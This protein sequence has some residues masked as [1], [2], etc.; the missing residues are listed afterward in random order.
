M[1]KA[2]TPE[3]LELMRKSGKIT[4]AALKKVL[5]AV[6]PGVNL[7]ELE[8]I[9][10]GEIKRLGGELSFPT[11]G[12]YKWA[13]CL[14]VNEELVHGI[15]RDIV[16]KKGD[17]LGIDI[18]AI[19]QG[20]HTDAAWS[21][22]VGGSGTGERAKFLQAGEEALWRAVKQAV[23]GKR[24]GDISNAIQ[25]TIEEAGFDVSRQLVGHGVG[26]EIHEKP[27]VP[28]FGRA[29]TGLE[30][31]VGMT[32]AIEAIYAQGNAY[33]SLADD[34]WTYVTKDG[35]LGGLFEMSVIVGKDKA[36]VLTDWRKI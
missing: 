4:A 8:E 6:V 20:Y 29:G 3:E 13:T 22:V 12:K 23:E 36:E 24:I 5:E 1:V 30:L 10:V 32:I 15:P 28:G 16:L 35:S 2:R 21:V 27:E 11:V 14:T 26:K 31:K 18:G 25:T 33:V 9:G 7:L 17:V 34:G 19:Y